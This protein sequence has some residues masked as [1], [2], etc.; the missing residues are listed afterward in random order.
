MGR[1]VAMLFIF[2]NL[3]SDYINRIELDCLLSDSVF[4]LLPYIVLV[5]IYEE[6][7]ASHTGEG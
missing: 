7:V 6:N 1:R 2:A 4:S 3:F 5:E